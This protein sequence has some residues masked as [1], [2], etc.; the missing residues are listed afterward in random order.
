MPLPMSRPPLY[1]LPG[2]ALVAVACAVAVLL[3][4]GTLGLFAW[5]DRAA[6][7]D[8]AAGV[9][10]NV[11]LLV[12]EHAARLVETS[13]LILRQVV[14]AADDAA[15]GPV[16][17]DRATWDRL[18]AL[19]DSM[20]YVAA[21]RLVRADG[22]VALTTRR[23]PAA[24]PDGTPLRAD[25]ESLRSLGD[26]RGGL[27]I[28][29]VDVDPA[30]GED[31][32]LIVLSR[33]LAAPSGAFRGI[34][35]VAVSPRYVREIYRAFDI[36][37][38]TEVA[39]LRPDQ[40]VL[41]REPGE[42]SPAA[43]DALVARHRV[44]GFDLEAEVT[45]P[46]AGVNALWSAQAE[47]YLLYGAAALLAVGGLGTLA[48][49]RAR[50]E[51]LAEHALKHA[52]DTL[53]ERVRQRTAELEDANHR[54]EHAVAD[55]EILLKE[56]QHRVKNNL[57]VIC[58]LLRLQSNRVDESARV[59][60]DESLRRIQ[61]MSLVHEL[62]YRSAEPAR[63]DF[64]DCLRQLC[65]SLARSCGPTAARVTVTAEPWILDVDR[66]MPLALI[67]SELVS[68]A[69]RHAFPDGRE[70]TVA[71]S[72]ADSDGGKRLAVADDGVGLPA[73]LLAPG[74]AQRRG[75]LGLILLQALANQ[76]GASV[77]TEIGPGTTV[78]LT[79]PTVARR[80]AA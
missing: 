67:A 70:G 51:R 16:P 29:R 53:E 42:P 52:Y 69:L 11:S 71:V 14:A 17:A 44:D 60:F 23:F 34:A 50:R 3:T 2:P 35:S 57:T 20:P 77:R 1:R 5:R 33:P 63:I 38:G 40:T 78:T 47:R 49:Q 41:V 55:K 45:I 26:G 18:V 21:I 79:V 8:R 43:A 58:S 32:P 31:E 73:E 48:F 72:L 66:A 36:G 27:H 76:A 24:A 6:A 64:A 39:L 65:D 12:A 68:N 19:S 54:L 4:V 7:F 61:S 10:A 25:A 75:A 22:T 13:D 37:Y 28:A 74:V 62:L 30:S 80:K 46:R 15:G 9:A 56:V 59:A